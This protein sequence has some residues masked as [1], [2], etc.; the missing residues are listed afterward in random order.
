MTLLRAYVAPAAAVTTPA[1]PAP[2]LPGL[3]SSLRPL[4]RL[5]TN[6]GEEAA[7]LRRF[8]YK[9]KNQH[10]GSGWWRRIVEVDRAVERVKAE[11]GG[12]LGEFGIRCVC[13]SGGAG[14]AS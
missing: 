7:L 4:K 14:D 13:T 2:A 12:L 3:L 6:F 9:N 10:K 11:F 5:L 8:T 1:A